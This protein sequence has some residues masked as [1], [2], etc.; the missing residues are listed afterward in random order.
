MKWKLNI[1]KEVTVVTLVL[2]VSALIAFSERR[3]NDKVCQNVVIELDNRHENHF[4]DEAD[5]LRLVEN[6]GVAIRGTTIDRLNLRAIESK[7]MFDKHIANAQ[8][9]GDLKGNLVVNVELRRPMA[10][11]VQ[12]DAPDAYIAED[13]AVMAVSD[14]YTARVLLISG[15]FVK[16]LLATEDLSKTEE[17]KKVLDM[18]RFINDDKFWKAQI[19]QMDIN[20]AGK[21][22]LFPEVSGQR[23]EF[24]HAENVEE[25]F[26]KLMIFYK[27][28]LPQRGWT[29]YSRVNLEYEGQIIAE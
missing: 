8:L 5:V 22:T 14:K 21:I 19:T 13:G 20:A 24:G 7:L 2:G 15:G 23:I 26:E 10:R 11:I 16:Q 4:L 12:Q 25:K 9:F 29:R 17:G 28:I 18:I 6:S 3:L 1:R 27:R